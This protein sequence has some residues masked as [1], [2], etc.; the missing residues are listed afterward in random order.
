MLLIVLL[1]S[2]AVSSMATELLRMQVKRVYVHPDPQSLK[3]GS[4]KLG[5]LLG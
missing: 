5:E 3:A 4:E 2:V 1:M